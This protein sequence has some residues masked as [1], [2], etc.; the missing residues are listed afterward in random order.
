MALLATRAVPSRSLCE[1]VPADPL[2]FSTNWRGAEPHQ[3]FSNANRMHR[4]SSS[5]LSEYI[6]KQ[7][8]EHGNFETFYTRTLKCDTLVADGLVD[9]GRPLTVQD[10]QQRKYTPT[11]P[12]DGDVVRISY[13]EYMQLKAGSRRK[14]REEQMLVERR[15]PSFAWRHG[16]AKSTKMS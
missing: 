9:N 12:I 11:L 10:C 4:S 3:I 15:M 5:L 14:L 8:A 16:G 13:E 7:V 2:P 6:S 1:G